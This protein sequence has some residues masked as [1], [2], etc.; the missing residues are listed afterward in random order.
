[1]QFRADVAKLSAVIEA[2]TAEVAGA[3]A[4]AIHRKL[5]Q[6]TP[7]RS[8][9]ARASWNIV[10]SE[11]P[12]LSVP[13]FHPGNDLNATPGE[14][15]AAIS[16]Y[17]PYLDR[18]LN[19]VPYTGTITVDGRKLDAAVFTVSNNLFYIEHLNNGSSR[20]APA[21]FFQTAVHEMEFAIRSQIGHF[22]QRKV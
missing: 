17:Q 3:V 19:F 11:N 22:Q 12:D 5:V 4:V 21:G 15:S 9:R 6:V 20:K 7:L 14:V 2:H 16:F 10:Q 8:G 1:M 18:N 13:P